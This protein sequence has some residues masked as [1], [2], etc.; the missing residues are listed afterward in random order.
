M[1]FRRIKAHIAKEDWFSVL[2]DFVIVVFGVFMG[3]Q[4]SNWNQA[5]DDQREYKLA[6]DRVID[7]AN[8][9]IDSLRDISI[10]SA[11]QIETVRLSIDALRSCEH[12]P[13][14][15]QLVESGLA[16][17]TGTYTIH[18][19]TGA[20][21]EIT[22]SPTLLAQ[23][24]RLTRKAFSAAKFVLGVL[25]TEAD[26]AE[27]LPFRD[28]PESNPLV[29]LGDPVAGRINYYGLSK[30]DTKYS[31]K[32]TKPVNELCQDD[33]LLKSLYTW[34]R[35]QSKLPV[36]ATDMSTEMRKIIATAAQALETF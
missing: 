7:E 3:I 12:T 5:L 31:L 28:R 8:T 9:N 17:I 24:S 25:K 21:D 4:V 33:Q 26:F 16:A 1:I 2:V 30:V 18:I 6:L 36:G 35:F 10:S 19:Q 20:I 27:S 29:I 14:N 22:S 13:K 23:Q 32:V 34:H 11:K 15:L